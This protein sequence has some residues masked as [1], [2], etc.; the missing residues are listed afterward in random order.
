MHSFWSEE[1]QTRRAE[2]SEGSLEGYTGY[3][4]RRFLSSVNGV[5]WRHSKLVNE[6][7]RPL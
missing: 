4:H 2:K 3:L 6:R 7:I 1:V 5:T